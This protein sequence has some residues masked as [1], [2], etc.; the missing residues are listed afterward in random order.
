MSAVLLI[1]LAALWAAVLI[2]ATLRTR[3]TA[4]EMRS[5]D[6]FHMA[7]RTLSRRTMPVDGRYIMI[8]TPAVTDAPRRETRAQMAHRRTM[9]LRLFWAAGGSLVLV[10]LFGGPWLWVHALADLALG[11]YVV[12][13][14]REAVRRTAE[15]R[16]ERRQ[17]VRQREAEERERR[18]AA[19]AAR[20]QR[21]AV[22]AA[23]AP[24]DEP[25]RRRVVGG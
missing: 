20:R 6:G 15:L 12:W 10:A 2:P 8:P 25:V 5:I 19:I 21:E 11:G 18:A 22:R 16:Q 24:V 4:S 3:D 13:L 17:E 1:V 9:L 14:R 7:M 23:L